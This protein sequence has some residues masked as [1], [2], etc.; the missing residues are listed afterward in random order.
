MA[1]L[2]PTDEAAVATFFEDNFAA[3]YAFLE[4][5]C[6]EVF[7]ARGEMRS[8]VLHHKTYLAWVTFVEIRLGGLRNVKGSVVELCQRLSDLLWYDPRYSDVVSDPF[9]P[10]K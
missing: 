7:S 2:D 1:T 9:G 10:P 5:Q 8:L 3:F 6:P 4:V